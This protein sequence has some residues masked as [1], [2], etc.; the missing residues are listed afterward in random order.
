MWNPPSCRSRPLT[1]PG[2]SSNVGTGGLVLWLAL[3]R[4]Q[5]CLTACSDCAGVEMGGPGVKPPFRRSLHLPCKACFSISS[6]WGLGSRQMRGQNFEVFLQ[7]VLPGSPLSSGRLGTGCGSVHVLQRDQ[8]AQNKEG[9]VPG[10]GTKWAE[11]KALLCQMY[12]PQRK[13]LLQTLAKK[14]TSGE[15]RLG[16]MVVLDQPW[17]TGIP[18]EAPLSPLASPPALGKPLVIRSQGAPGHSRAGEQL[19]P[20]PGTLELWETPA[21]IPDAEDRLTV[22]S[23][24]P[25]PPR[26]PGH[27]TVTVHLPPLPRENGLNFLPCSA[28][29]A[30][31]SLWADGV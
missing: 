1:S 16:E 30:S 6:L 22:D 20:L 11:H 10:T 25:R 2:T 17:G 31:A 23:P 4:P 26:P 5:C 3:H 21:E 8:R 15:S 27:V 13:P 18:P 7:L 19:G 24:T 9:P 28:A 29:L 14:R 12:W